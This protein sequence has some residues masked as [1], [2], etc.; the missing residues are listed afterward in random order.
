MEPKKVDGY[1]FFLVF[2]F[3]CLVFGFGFWF[4]YGFVSVW[5]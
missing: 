1:P 2:G 5:L 4:L 3:W